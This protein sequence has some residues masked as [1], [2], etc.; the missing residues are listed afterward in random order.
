M[1]CVNPVMS[2]PEGYRP[3]S[4]RRCDQ[5]TIFDSLLVADKIKSRYSAIPSIPP[6]H[7]RCKC[8]G[9]CFSS[10]WPPQTPQHIH[11]PN[12]RPLPH[13]HSQDTH[14]CKMPIA[15]RT[16]QTLVATLVIISL[17]ALAQ[18]FCILVG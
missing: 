2:T 11:Y 14:Q 3:V 9:Y 18:A 15:T 5:P 8:V 6:T 10:S 17:F 13:V 16:K 4:L 12:A 1:R 7:L